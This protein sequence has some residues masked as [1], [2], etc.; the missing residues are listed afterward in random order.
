MHDADVQAG[1]AVRV[2]RAHP[3]L[4]DDGRFLQV[5]PDF[6][7]LTAAEDPVPAGLFRLCVAG[8]AGDAL[9]GELHPG[10]VEAQ[11]HIA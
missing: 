4:L 10:R 7:V 11:Q 9:L 1:L 8:Q 2:D 3:L 5:E 6:V